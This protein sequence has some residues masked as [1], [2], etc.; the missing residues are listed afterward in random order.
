[1]E[2]EGGRC[3]VGLLRESEERN[4]KILYI[5]GLVGWASFTEVVGLQ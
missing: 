5:Y 2:R 3:A 4:H 1:M